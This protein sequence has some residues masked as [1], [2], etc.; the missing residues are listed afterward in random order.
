M[1]EQGTSG[2]GTFFEA[3]NGWQYQVNDEGHI[4]YRFGNDESWRHLGEQVGLGLIEW[5]QTDIWTEKEGEIYQ[6]KCGSWDCRAP[7]CGRA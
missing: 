1:S 3:S 6:A 2:N 7:E 4:V 5:A